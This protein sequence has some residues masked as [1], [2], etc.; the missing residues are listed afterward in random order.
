MGEVA[1]GEFEVPANAPVKRDG[2]EP[3]VWDADGPVPFPGR[4]E[5]VDIDHLVSEFSKVRIKF[6]VNE[7]KPVLETDEGHEVE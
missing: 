4:V 3:G 2:P 5:W 6:F 7:V 1:S